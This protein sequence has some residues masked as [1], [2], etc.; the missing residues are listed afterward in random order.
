MLDAH[1]DRQ[2]THTPVPRP[3]SLWPASAWPHAPSVRLPKRGWDGSCSVTDESG[4]LTR[5]S[6][7]DS[8]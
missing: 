5:C 7:Q 3:I 2:E 8:V 4:D 1:G 6:R